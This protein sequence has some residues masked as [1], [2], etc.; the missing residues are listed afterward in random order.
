VRAPATQVAAPVAYPGVGLEVDPAGGVATG[1]GVGAA[2][3]TPP[4]TSSGDPERLTGDGV[5]AR[6]VT[7]EPLSC[8]P[9]LVINA[10]TAASNQNAS[11]GRAWF[12]F[13]WLSPE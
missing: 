7:V 5:P 1:L 12:A 13:T 4:S 8:R 3:S 2:R 6:T 11:N 10:A 9:R